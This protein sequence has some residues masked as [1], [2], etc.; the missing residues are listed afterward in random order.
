MNKLKN[1]WF[2]GIASG[3]VLT[4]AASGSA[5]AAPDVLDSPSAPT[6]KGH[7]ALV[8]DVADTG[9][10]LVA[11]GAR[12]HILVS[13]DQGDS[14]QQKPTPASV[15]LTAVDFVDDKLVLVNGRAKIDVHP[16]G[17]PPK[18]KDP[19]PKNQRL[20]VLYHHIDHTDPAISNGFERSQRLDHK[21][22]RR[23]H[24]TRQQSTKRT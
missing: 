17:L 9:S 10:R 20:G 16:A 6:K 4:L 14:W 11:V 22:S 15:L 19:N 21:H 13:D 7:E 3:F 2:K 18:D 5:H 8:L 23:R 12:G 1:H 24:D